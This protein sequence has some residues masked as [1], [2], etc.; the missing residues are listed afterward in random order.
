VVDD[1]TRIAELEAKVARLERMLE[2]APNFITWVS[3]E[4]KLLYV[5][6]LAPGFTLDDVVGQEVYAFLPPN[7]HDRLRTAVHDAVETGETQELVTYGVASADRMGY[8]LTRISPLFENG[9]VTSL[10]LVA[11]DITEHEERRIRF[12]LALEATG[13]GIWTLDAKTK[14]GDMDA[15]SREI[16][17]VEPGSEIETLEDMIAQGIHP[18]DRALV[19]ERVEEAFTTGVYRPIEH[20]IVRPDGSVRWVQASGVALDDGGRDAVRLVGGMMDVTQRRALESRLAEAHR[21]ESIG[22]LAG[23]IAH[24][25]NNM[26]TA[27]LGNVDFALQD[28]R[29]V[30]DVRRLLEEVRLGAQRSAA[31]TSQLLAFAR[32]QMIRPTV[33]DPNRLISRLDTLLSRLLGEHVQLE[34]S[35]GAES[36][37]EVDPSQF[38]Q[39]VLNLL[40]NARD[41]MPEGGRV[42]LGTADVELGSELAPEL[43]AGRYVC[44]TVRDT[45]SGIE[46]NALGRVFDPF[47]S[48][49]EGGTGLGLATC[50]GIA[51]Q[52][53]GHI[54]VES[55]PG[56]G[57]TF[58]VYLPCAKAQ[59]A[60]KANAVGGPLRGSGESILVV[61]DEP[62]VRRLLVRTLEDAG[63]RVE[64]AGDPTEAL[65]LASE[66]GPFDLLL[67]DVVMP[68]MSGLELGRRLRAE[69]SV[70]KVL[71][72]SGYAREGI[73]PE[74][75]QGPRPRLIHKPFLPRDLLHAVRALLEE[76]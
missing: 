22:R 20:R 19:A 4:G 12:E 30:E 50:Y 36:A 5:N 32:R 75:E 16:F 55:K 69:G 2:G 52:N 76:S 51:K 23:G 11:T 54:V 3:T 38:E 14:S 70:P 63:Y 10:L 68:G 73:D 27:I 34:V 47:F 42:I 7:F 65:H 72:V 15:K 37:I 44:M 6:R 17:G 41:A 25:F 39:I 71:H 33:V 74:G 18:D 49:R 61:E 67:T 60:S 48:T 24:D 31:L 66:A 58:R 43:E 13:L 64:E 46:E 56:E 40:T 29:L 59:P 35:L 57:A 8:Y 45:G 1:A 28:S 26:L 62:L 21:L 53:R 9:E